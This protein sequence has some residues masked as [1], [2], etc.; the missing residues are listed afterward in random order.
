[1]KLNNG[2]NDN[3]LKGSWYP[4]REE[5]VFCNGG[6]LTKPLGAVKGVGNCGI[7]ALSYVMGLSVH[8]MESYWRH[9]FNKAPQWKGTVYTYEFTKMMDHLGIKRVHE[10]RNLAYKMKNDPMYK[11][12]FPACTI[13]NFARS[14][15]IPD[16]LYIVRASGHIMC[17]KDEMIMDQSACTTYWEHWSRRKHI[18]EV[19]RIQK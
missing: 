11:R 5:S 9:F 14:H 2:W 10:A 18:R 19:W 4:G 12:G 3:S 16:S 6:V 17:M 1:M 8:D 15:M 7:V 13:H